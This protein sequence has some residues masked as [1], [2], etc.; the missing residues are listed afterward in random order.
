MARQKY[1]HVNIANKYARDV[2][3]GRIAACVFVQLACQRHLD[4]LKREKQK[5]F[6]YRFDRAAGEDVCY[7]AELF[8]HVKG[9]WAGTNIHLQPWQCFILVVAF[10]WKRKSDGLRRFREIFA[11][12]PRKNGKSVLGAI[13]ALYLTFADGEAGAEGYTGATT[14]KQAWEV[15][16]PARQMA[17]RTPAFL[18]HYGVEVHAKR[19]VSLNSNSWLEPL[20][21]KPGDGS[22]PHCSI[23]DEYHEHKTPDLYDTMVTGMGARTQPMQAVISTAGTNLKGPCKV[24]QKEAEKVLR[25][26]LTNEELFVIIFTIDD[27]DDWQDLEVWKKANPNYGVSVQEDFLIRMHRDAMQLASKQNIIRCKHLNQWMNADVAWMNMVEFNKTADSSL[28]ISVFSHLDAYGAV[29]LSSKIDLASLGIAFEYEE[30]VYGFYR[31]YLP[32]RTI[33]LPENHH[34]QQWRHE[35][36]L[37]EAGEAV[38]DYSFIEQD[39]LNFARMLNFAV[40][41]YDPYQ[42]TQFATRMMDQG[43]PMVEIPHTVKNLSEPMKELEGRVLSGKFKHDGNPITTFC[44]SNVV[45]HVDKKDN[46]YPN[47]EF[48]EN[49]IDGA[50][51]TIMNMNRIIVGPPEYET[52]IENAFREL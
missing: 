2:V 6:I 22:S 33:N 1:P 5:N 21:G 14:E 13:I 46:I 28:D 40:V 43:L 8:P 32:R 11:L 17:L 34:Y 45:A 23:V 27:T 44:F 3:A 36:W 24:K 39:L 16:G 9:K 37:I 15:F 35:G 10:G 50:V 26:E 48:H 4:E 18:E 47:K 41:G 19:L 49:K 29:D 30:V 51:V 7:F 12:V 31:Y 25:G 38:I 42:A 52:E 20:I